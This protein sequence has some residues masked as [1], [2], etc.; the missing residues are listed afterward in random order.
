VIGLWKNKQCWRN[1][2]LVEQI[3]ETSGS[4]RFCRS[5]RQWVRN[6]M[7]ACGVYKYGGKIIHWLWSK[8]THIID[9][10][11]GRNKTN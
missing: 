4:S 6:R 11:T 1:T 8:K 5:Y 3:Q 10:Q 2:Y 7:A 9:R